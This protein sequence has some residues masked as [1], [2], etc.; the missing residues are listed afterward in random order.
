MPDAAELNGEE[1]LQVAFVGLEDPPDFFGE[2]YL[3]VLPEVAPGKAMG[4]NDGCVG[5]VLHPSVYGVE[6]LEVT[7]RTG[8]CEGLAGLGLH[9]EVDGEPEGRNALPELAHGPR[10]PGVSKAAGR[11]GAGEELQ[12]AYAPGVEPVLDFAE[13]GSGVGRYVGLR[14]MYKALDAVRVPGGGF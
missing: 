9:S 12:S 13:G 1:E 3:V 4:E 11:V 7:C 6:L 14:D 10:V 5:I 8:L 2:D